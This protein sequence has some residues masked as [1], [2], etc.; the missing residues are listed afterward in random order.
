MRLLC[1]A[2]AL[3][4]ARNEQKIARLYEVSINEAIFKSPGIR[5]MYLA[6][7]PSA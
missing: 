4:S 6:P 5:I 3:Q 7:Q 2:Y 1:G